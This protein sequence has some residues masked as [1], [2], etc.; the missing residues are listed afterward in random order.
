MRE[1]WTE[2]MTAACE[3]LMSAGCNDANTRRA[4]AMVEAARELRIGAAFGVAAPASEIDWKLE[5]RRVEAAQAVARREHAR[6]RTGCTP[7]RLGD[8]PA[9]DPRILAE[10]EKDYG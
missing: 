5:A 7:A 8:N 9:V 1:K 6:V 2:I 10:L 4:Q 3:L